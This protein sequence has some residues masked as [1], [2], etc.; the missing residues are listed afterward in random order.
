MRLVRLQAL[1]WR[2]STGR[3]VRYI[4]GMSKNPHAVALGRRGGKARIENLSEEERR[5]LGRKAG[6]AS[7][8]V[9]KAKAKER[10][11]KP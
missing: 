2:L 5:E 8:K 7:G 4:P 6:I 1:F 3:L 10:K 9:R 11:A